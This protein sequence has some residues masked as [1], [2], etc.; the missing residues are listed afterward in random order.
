LE[1]LSREDLDARLQLFID[2]VQ[3]DIALD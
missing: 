1:N 3:F 2:L